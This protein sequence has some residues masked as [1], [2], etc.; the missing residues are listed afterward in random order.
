MGKQ[1]APEFVTINPNARVPALIDHFNE[2][3]SIWESWCN[4]LVLGI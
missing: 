2:N 4:Y 3:T 1:R